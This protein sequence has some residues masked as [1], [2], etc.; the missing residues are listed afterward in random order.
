MLLALTAGST[1]GK[2][3][4]YYNH[5]CDLADQLVSELATLQCNVKYCQYALI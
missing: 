4:K 3:E 5:V 2:M 1:T